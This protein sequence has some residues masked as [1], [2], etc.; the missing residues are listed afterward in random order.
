MSAPVNP[1]PAR[2]ASPPPAD[3][4]IPSATEADELNALREQLKTTPL[5]P[6][7]LGYEVFVY[8][9]RDGSTWLGW[10]IKRLRKRWWSRSPTVV[11]TTVS[12]GFEFH[13]FSY[14]Y[15]FHAE[16]NV[17]EH[18]LPEAHGIRVASETVF[19]VDRTHAQP[20]EG[21]LSLTKEGTP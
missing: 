5:K 13:E 11:K 20:P 15:R 17:Y 10:T 8:T 19:A 21:A 9:A 18:L 3:F 2:S 12:K 6:D 14:P 7:V 16:A 4:S 1:R